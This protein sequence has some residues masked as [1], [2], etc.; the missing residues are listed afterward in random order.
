MATGDIYGLRKNG[1]DVWE[2]IDLKNYLLPIVDKASGSDITT[3]TN[4][5][6]YVTSKAISDANLVEHPLIAAISDEES[7]LETGTAIKFPWPFDAILTR[8]PKAN[9]NEAPDGSD[10][11]IEI[12]RDGV[13]IFSTIITIDD[14]TK[15]S[16]NASVPA[17]LSQTY[18]YDDDEIEIL[19]NQIGSNTAGVGAKVTFYYRREY[20]NEITEPT[21][22][23]TT[24]TP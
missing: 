16:K 11:E 21:T 19:I 3:G 20:N 13:S 14:G 8:I 18:M 6:K 22:T 9:V 15:S 17:V 2:E 7:D 4:D 5:N 10:I 1:S 23:T 24:T 12:K